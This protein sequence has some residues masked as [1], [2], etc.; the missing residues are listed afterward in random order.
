MNLHTRNNVDLT[1]G[2]YNV[3]S[4][5][6]KIKLIEDILWVF[7][8]GR[9]NTQ[10]WKCLFYSYIYFYSLYVAE[11]NLLTSLIRMYIFYFIVRSIN[12]RWANF[13]L[14]LCH[15]TYFTF[16]FKICHFFLTD[17]HP[18]KRVKEDDRWK[19]KKH[20]GSYLSGYQIKSEN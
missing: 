6:C 4:C 16:I 20:L 9:W 1:P 14:R 10:L 12:D 13:Y 19:I 15:S 18:R 2:Y 5:T 11:I 7:M 17:V 8:C 3:P